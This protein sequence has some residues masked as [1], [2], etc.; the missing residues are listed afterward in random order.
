MVVLKAFWNKT[1]ARYLLIH[2]FSLWCSLTFF[3]LVSLTK[4]TTIQTSVPLCNKKILTYTLYLSELSCNWQNILFRFLAHEIEEENFLIEELVVEWETKQIQNDEYIPMH[5]L[6]Y[7]LFV[8]MDYRALV[9]RKV[10]EEVIL[11]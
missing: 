1:N 2:T 11:S 6:R 9:P 3:E 4:N 10:C 5:R 7:E 8:R